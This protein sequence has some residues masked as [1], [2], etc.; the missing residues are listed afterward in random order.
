MKATN[1]QGKLVPM[2]DCYLQSDLAANGKLYGSNNSIQLFFDNIPDISDKKGA[3]YND[4][5]G[6]W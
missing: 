5:T 6:N 3:K 2:K 1:N 4:E